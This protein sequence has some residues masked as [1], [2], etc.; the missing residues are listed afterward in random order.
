M[1]EPCQQ[2]ESLR[3][4]V[5][6]VRPKV[7][8]NVGAVARVMRNMGLRRLCLVDPEADIDDPRGR[9]L[10]THSHEILDNATIVDDLDAALSNEVLVAATSGRRGGLFRKQ[11]IGPP[12]EIAKHLVTASFEGPVS[13]VFGP[14]TSGL[15]NAEIARCHYL[16]HIPTDEAHLAL[17]L[18]Q[19]VA[20][21]LYELRRCWLETQKP[22][23]VRDDAAPFAYQ[24]VMFE[25]LRASLEALHFL[26]GPKAD[27][28]MHALR[29]LI[30]RARPSRMEVD[31]LM[32]L[33]KQIQWFCNNHQ[34]KES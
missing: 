11:T 7:S 16:I 8:A 26:Y 25:K 6:L 5:V 23:T 17:N 34:E 15:T 13:L 12:E 9:L 29:H 19:A 22:N 32:G 10:A 28:L 30:T 4:S 18:A 20:I 24:E 33:A 31:V 21:C 3:C 2:P 14:E 1:N 27:S